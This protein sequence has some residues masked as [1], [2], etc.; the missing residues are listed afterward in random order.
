MAPPNG[1]IAVA[2]HP[3]LKDDRLP[4]RRLLVIDDDEALLHA[5]ATAFPLR[6]PCITVSTAI[7][8]DAALQHLQHERYDLILCDVRMP[9]MDGL[10]F[11][12]QVT[13]LPFCPPVALITGDGDR[14]MSEQ[15][16]RHG[17]VAFIKKPFEREEFLRTVAKLLGL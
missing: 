10:T 17:A 7:S 13:Q 2:A 6:L 16:R 9:N 3:L 11:L 1:G 15:A 14:F 4:A 5:L 8:G 12:Q